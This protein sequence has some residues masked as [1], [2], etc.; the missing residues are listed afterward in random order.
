[1]ESPRAVRLHSGD[2]HIA[3]TPHRS[4]DFVT[5]TFTISKPGS[6]AVVLSGSGGVLD[7]GYERAEISVGRWDRAGHRFAMVAHYSKGAHC[8]LRLRLVVPVGAGLRVVDFDERDARVNVR[9]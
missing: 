9:L 4:A 1:A 8:C 6:R 2:L 5:P 3:I 7:D